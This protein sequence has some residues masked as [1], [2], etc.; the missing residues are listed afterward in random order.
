MPFIDIGVTLREPGKEPLFP[1]PPVWM[2]PVSDDPRFNDPPPPEHHPDW[3]DLPIHHFD[4]ATKLLE[5]LVRLLYSY[6]LNCG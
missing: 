5:G 2:C 3:H 6:S 4:S 1:P